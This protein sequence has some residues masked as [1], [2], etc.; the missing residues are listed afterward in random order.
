M[1]S[2]NAKPAEMICITVT[3]GGIKVR[4]YNTGK[5]LIRTI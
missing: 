1:I 4:V 3:P 2:K 5:I